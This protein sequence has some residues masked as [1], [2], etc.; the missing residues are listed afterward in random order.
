MD[1]PATSEYPTAVSTIGGGTNPGGNSLRLFFRNSVVLEDVEEFEEPLPCF[2]FF[3]RLCFERFSASV[4]KVVVIRML[5]PVGAACCGLPA[6]V[7]LQRSPRKDIAYGGIVNAAWLAVCPCELRQQYLL[8]ASSLR[9]TAF[10]TAVTDVV[11]WNGG[12]VT[13]DAG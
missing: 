6:V 13:I 1:S 12:P 5:F 11:G 10:A 9:F 2:R 4:G 8:E 7:P 3:W